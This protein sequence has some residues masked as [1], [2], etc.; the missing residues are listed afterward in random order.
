VIKFKLRIELKLNYK[1]FWVQKDY[2]DDKLKNK[3][4]INIYIYIFKLK[5]VKRT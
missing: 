4:K 3:N 5:I 1:N 2:K